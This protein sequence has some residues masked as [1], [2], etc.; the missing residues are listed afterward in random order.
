MD[1][2]LRG[3]DNRSAGMTREEAKMARR[4]KEFEDG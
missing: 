2:C 1:S 4:A 3:D